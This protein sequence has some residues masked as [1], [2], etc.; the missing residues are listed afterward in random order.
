[1]SGDLVLGID[2]GLNGAMALVDLQTGA[3]VDVWDI[4]TLTTKRREIDGYTLA[5]RI[6][7]LAGRLVE[8]WIET[9]TPR[10]GQGL[11]QTVASLRTF[12]IL[13]GLVMANFI[14]LH[15]VAPSAWKRAMHVTGDKDEAR[16]AASTCW[17]H[18]AGQW[19]A[20][21][22]HDRAEAALIARYG[23]QLFA[24]TLAGEAA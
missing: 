11:Q 23:Q 18:C 5:A 17:P 12:G 14:P 19:P 16:K 8:A 15:E 4:P 22:D 24:R 9:P 3:L 20:K 13:A 1:M 10:P 21:K 6:D 2:P 7:E